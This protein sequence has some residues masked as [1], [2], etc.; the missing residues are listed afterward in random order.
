[1]STGGGNEG[2]VVNGI[3]VPV[4]LSRLNDL[5][6]QLLR[7]IHDLQGNAVATPI[8]VGVDVG[9]AQGTG[10]Q[11]QRTI[12]ESQR[13]I[14]MAFSGILKPDADLRAIET[15]LQDIIVTSDRAGQK[16]QGVLTIGG[17]RGG[18]RYQ[19]S[20]TADVPAILASLA[21][22]Q[23]ELGAGQARLSLSGVA[24]DAAD[25][26][27][28]SGAFASI[29]QLEREAGKA[30]RAL[31]GTAE[32]GEKVAKW[33]ETWAGG[34]R[35][36]RAIGAA[37]QG[38]FEKWMGPELGAMAAGG[39]AMIGGG[40]L[41]HMGWAITDAIAKIP[42]TIGSVIEQFRAADVAR[43]Q[44]MGGA[45]PEALGPITPWQGDVTANRVNA[46]WLTHMG[47]GHVI[48]QRMQPDKFGAGFDY[49][50]GLKTLQEQLPPGELSTPE[51]IDVW[52]QRNARYMAL[53]EFA[54][55]FAGG[56]NYLQVAN[57]LQQGELH[58]SAAAAETLMTNQPGLIEEL[59][60]HERTRHPE[61]DVLPWETQAGRTRD[62]IK[63]KYGLGSA[64]PSERDTA[65]NA[66]YQAYVKTVESPNA[67]SG[68]AARTSQWRPQFDLAEAVAGLMHMPGAPTLEMRD[69]MH[70]YST[71]RGAEGYTRKGSERWAR[72]YSD[73]HRGMSYEQLMDVVP[74]A[75][76][77]MGNPVP[78]L[79]G[80]A[81]PYDLPQ[82]AGQPKFSFSTASEFANKMQMEAS[83]HM[84][85]HAQNT[86]NN[87]RDMVEAQR[88]TNRLLSQT[89][90]P[91]ASGRLGDPS[92]RLVHGAPTP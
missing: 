80:P 12:E 67:I 57:A 73:R 58:K 89:V 22:H 15:A 92:D 40:M 36:Q 2:D 33:L 54:Q 31:G 26:S 16:L 35:P 46:R 66:V 42:G 64:L 10:E 91:G 61:W 72:D 59:V 38:P 75:E 88:E 27:G 68:Y 17:Q 14:K 18:P 48:T 69:A 85:D 44:L 55:T 87:T 41:F 77:A 45:G 78:W 86:A 51:R 65:W 7:T 62:I 60:N 32:H 50:T 1:M 63:G 5:A 76:A 79:G 52:E 23:P 81:K 83:I 34:G 49:E 82:W 28:A 21:Q 29:T 13:K 3:G 6:S 56:R 4:Y 84:A 47:L 25:L 43:A 39:A 8:R 53:A 11:I 9:V 70:N 90:P 24:R 30:A 20:G 74:G 19:I 37:I 71:W